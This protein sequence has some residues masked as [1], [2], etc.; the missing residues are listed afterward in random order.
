MF[1]HL[2][3]HHYACLICGWSGRENAELAHMWLSSLITLYGCITTSQMDR[4]DDVVFKIHYNGVFKYDPLRYEQFRVVE[5][6]ACITYKVI[7]SH[8]LDMLVAKVKDNMLALF[9]C[10]PGL[11]IDSGRLKLIENDADVH[12]L[13]IYA[14]NMSIEE[15]VAWAEEEASSPYLRSSPL[16]SRPFRNDMK[17]RVLFTNMYCVEDEGFEMYPPLNED[18]VGKDDLLVWCSNLENDAAKILE[19]MSEGMNDDANIDID[20]QVLAKQ[21]LL[22]KGKSL[23]TDDDIVTTKKRKI[24]SRG[25]GI[26]IREND[27]VNVVSMDN[28][29]D[30]NDH[31]DHQSKT[32]RDESDKSFDYLSNG[33]D[34]VIE[35]RKRRIRFK[36]NGAE[37]ADEAEVADD[38]HHE[39]G[40]EERATVDVDKYGEIDDNGLGLAPLIREHE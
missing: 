6:Q 32:D 3:G 10:I 14:G 29:S 36:C 2:C 22:D 12:A 31:G 5:M 4:P 24:V 8:L 33:E 25:N 13:K 17:G 34:V 7:F 28:E 21:K 11:D 39:V 35:L 37:V 20:E 27:S 26:S 18:E 23:M 9:F 19:G 38:D 15:L 40:D 30:S 16:K 1:G